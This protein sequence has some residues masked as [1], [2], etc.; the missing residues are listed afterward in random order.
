ML[1]DELEGILVEAYLRRNLVESGAFQLF[2]Y[3]V[4]LGNLCLLFGDVA[5]YFYQLHTV[6][7]RTRN[8]AQVIGCG[9]EEHLGEV[10]IHIEIVVVEG[11][12]LFRVQHFEQGRC[13]VAVEIALRHLV[14]LVEDEDRIAAACLQHVLD[15]AARHGS[16]IGAAVTA[17]FGFI[18][19]TAQRHA[20]ILALHG[21]C[22]ALAQTG[23]S[24]ARRTVEAED[25]T[26]AA[27]VQCSYGEEFQNALLHILHAV[28]VV[29]QNALGTGQTEVV[30]GVGVPR[31]IYHGLQESYLYRIV[32]T[33]RVQRV[34]LGNFFLEDF[35]SFLAP[36]LLFR[37]LQNLLLLRTGVSFY[38]FFPDVLDL[39]LEEV[40]LLLLIKV[41]VG[42]VLNLS[43]DA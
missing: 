1:D 3:E 9:D 34:E 8:D 37:L 25:R 6:E 29:V 41:V 28:V 38:Q 35:G 18:V 16:H 22:D 5:A 15:D 7:E 13:W 40:F 12:V 27:A 21:C 19:Q 4:A 26:L 23:L 31:Q 33:L 42:F 20:Y 2:R 17:D 36:V 14:N 32:R 39:L 43:L 11:I 10:V 24:Y 30:L